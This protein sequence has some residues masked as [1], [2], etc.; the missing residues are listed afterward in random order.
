MDLTVFGRVIAIG[1]VIQIPIFLLMGPIVDKFH[2]L[3]A[4]I[5][6]YLLLVISG[7]TSFV[8]IHGTMS[9]SICVIFIFVS[10]AV[11]QGVLLALGP[12]LFP[13]DKY[14]QFCSANAI[15]FGLGLMFGHPACGKFLDIMG[16][17]RYA[18][19]WFFCFSAVGAVLIWMVYRD[20]L[21][22]GGDDHYEPP[23]KGQTAEPRGFEVAASQPR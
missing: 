14:G 10:V 8:F 2:P 12:R 4:G 21:H 6:G 15:V 23:L 17:H 13:R 16:S 18:F 1:S 9:F 3:R 22:L 20:W 5:V 11:Y 19:L 7:I